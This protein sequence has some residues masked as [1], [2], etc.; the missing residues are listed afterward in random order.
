MRKLDIVEDTCYVY[1][2]YDPEKDD[3]V[4]VG[5]SDARGHGIREKNHLMKNKTS[6]VYKVGLGSTT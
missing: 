6:R 1:V 4:Y 5:R 3:V 2:F